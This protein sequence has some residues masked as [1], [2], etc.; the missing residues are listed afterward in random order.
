MAF[1][2]LTKQHGIDSAIFGT[3][4]LGHFHLV[5]L[6]KPALIA[7]GTTGNHGPAR[8][9]NV[10]CQSHTSWAP[11]AASQHSS[12]SSSSLFASGFTLDGLESLGTLPAADC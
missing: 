6:L 9:V 10:S 8:I 12:S 4:H 3:N 5:E 7:G 11:A 2:T 1:A